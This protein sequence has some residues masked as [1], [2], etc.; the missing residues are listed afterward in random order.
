MDSLGWFESAYSSL[1]RA[2][3]HCDSLQRDERRVR[4]QRL[5]QG[6]AVLRLKA[7]S[8]QT[9]RPKQNQQEPVVTQAHVG[10][11]DATDQYKL[12]LRTRTRA[13]TRLT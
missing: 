12:W 2:Q 9:A 4:S 7:A 1:V 13:K 5:P 10:T 11:D 6:L 8:L 3:M